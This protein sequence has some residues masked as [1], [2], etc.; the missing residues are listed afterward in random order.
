MQIYKMIDNSF[1]KGR[2]LGYL[3]YYERSRRF[4][5]E[6][7]S[8]LDEW[9][10]PFMF[11]GFV[12][13]GCYSID[14]FWTGKFVAQRIIPP[15][16]QNLGMILR[17]NGLREYDEFRL[18]K[19]SEGRCAQDEI[20]IEKAD[21][22]ELV[23]EVQE[24]L[25]RKVS[26]CLPVNDGHVIV[27]FK[28]GTVSETDVN[29]MVSGDRIFDNVLRDEE[30]FR[31][32]KTAPGGNGI[33][34]GG[35]RNIPAEKLYESGVEYNIKQS[36]MLEYV[37]LRLIDTAAVCEMLDCTRQYVGQLVTAGKLVPVRNVSN[38]N[39]FMKSDIE[40]EDLL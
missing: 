14:S 29:S 35:D 15:D 40:R 6:L 3:F 21:Y 1:D 20:C 31:N 37:K 16:R 19:L 30:L 4:F 23:P 11:T 5:A 38:N 7:L 25:D 26:D 39:L 12:R 34:W 2:L 8:E 13:R 10:A 18:L 17:E 24:R 32:V 33:E 28:D 22:E 27:F 9:S 36:D